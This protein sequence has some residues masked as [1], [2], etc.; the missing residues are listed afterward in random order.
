MKHVF[1]LLAVLLSLSACKTKDDCGN[2]DGP[3]ASTARSPG[4]APAGADAPKPR[5]AVA[6]HGG[7][8]VIPKDSAP[9][10]VKAFESA[11][12][13]ALEEAVRLLEA[14]RP[15]L[16]VVETVVRRLEDDP[17]F[18][19][20]RGAVFTATGAH[21][22]DSSI[23]DGRNLACGAVAGVKT[24]RNPISLARMVMEKTR[25]VLL[26]ADGAESFATEM[27]VERVAN[28][29]FDT[30]VRRSSFEAWK[31]E[32]AA[33][34]KAAG[35]G[36]GMASG[37]PESVRQAW[38]YGTVGCVVRDSA[39]HLAAATS[40]GGMTGKRFGRVGDTPVVGAGTYAND[41]TCAVSCTGT[42]EEFIRHGVAR[43]IHA[44]MAYR[45]TSL[46][47]A[48]REIVFQRL[49]PDDGGLI[50][51]DKDGRIAMEYNSEGMFRAAADANGLRLVKIWE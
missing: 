10:Q 43:D 8:G 29:W 14:G 45:G 5:W 25:H 38:N 19:A 1:S 41:A 17:N 46:G 50:A 22:L 18:N 15:A 42:G 27:G 37:T 13:G 34:T 49:K 35:S 24:V 33:K 30:D 51:V 16:D 47:D 23:M 3:V 4:S 11:L 20:G 40:T 9:A 12:S 7:A 48:L 39:G 2:S 6:L 28:S 32:Q 21:E 31:A 36:G 44:Q 26:A